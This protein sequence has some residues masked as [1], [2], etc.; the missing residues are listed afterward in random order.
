MSTPDRVTIVEVGPR[1][2]FQMEK[3]FIPT[4]LKVEVIDRLSAAGVA[5]IEATSFVSPKVIPQMADAALVMSRITRR[6]G[7]R[8]IALVPNLVGAT[9]AMAAGSDELEFVIVASESYNRAN[10]GLSVDESLAAARDVAHAAK[11]A[12]IKVQVVIGCSFGCPLEGPVPEAQVERIARAAA[13]MG[14]AS[15]SLADSI[16]IA[17][18]A[19]VRR[20]V[21]RVSGALP[22]LPLSLH[23]HNT[24][25]LGLANVLAGFEAGIDTFDAGLGGLGGCPIFP[26]ATGNVATEDVVNLFEEMGVSTGIDLQGVREASR[27]LQDFLGRSLPSYILRVGTRA[28]LYGRLEPNPAPAGSPVPGQ[29]P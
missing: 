4:D 28:E 27:T 3:V 15:L 8:Y 2:G 10:V 9:R 24:R 23:I 13:A 29:A 20:L 25:G 26:G 11:A 22:G 14:I 18:P 12:G 19:Q 16:G 7:T 6:P 21:E 5:R 17:N 1:D